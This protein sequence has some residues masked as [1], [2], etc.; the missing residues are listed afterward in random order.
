VSWR[1]SCRTKDRNLVSCSHLWVP[2]SSL[3]PL[4]FCSP[5]YLLEFRPGALCLTPLPSPVLPVSDPSLRIEVCCA[6]ELVAGRGI[7]LVLTLYQ[8]AVLLLLVLNFSGF[9]AS[10]LLAR[11]PD[12]ALWKEDHGRLGAGQWPC[13]LQGF[14]Y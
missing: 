10:S 13:C 12:R 3:R 8:N 4:S 14:S 2:P 11:G 7:C 1:V 5:T 9:S 6:E